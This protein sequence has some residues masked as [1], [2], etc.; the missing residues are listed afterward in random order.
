LAYKKRL[1]L[2]DA[3]VLALAAGGGAWL[4]HRAASG[5]EYQWD[6][7]FIPQYLLLETDSGWRPGLLS[8][9]LLTTLRLSVFSGVLALVFGLATGVARTSPR[10]FPRLCAAAYV[11]LVRNTPPLV[12][13]FVFYYFLGDQLMT[14]IGMEDLIYGLSE[15]QRAWVGAILG[16]ARQV[17]AFLSAV[18]TLALFEGAYIAEIVR[19]GIESVER[20]QWESSAALGF[21]RAGQ[22][23]HVVLPQA[24][25]RMLPALAGQLV[26]TIKDSAIVSV[27][28]IQELTFA[29][30]ELMSATYRTF[31]I[32]ITVL[33]L[34]FLLTFSLSLLVRRMETRLNKYRPAL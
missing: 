30:Q 29:G 9:G 10:L 19:A 18:L 6:W 26:S 11:G 34:Y 1:S 32:W 21:S 2:L 8:Q 4:L 13:V 14:L 16:P 24:L 17:P 27:I 22:L 12:L 20:G 5:L 23:R 7:S 28:S 25:A 31:E 33:G 3:A 15:G